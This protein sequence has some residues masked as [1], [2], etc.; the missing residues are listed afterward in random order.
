MNEALIIGIIAAVLVIALISRDDDKPAAVMRVT[1]YGDSST[2]G[3][4]YDAGMVLQR[5]APDPVTMVQAAAGGRLLCVNRAVNG[6]TL[7]ELLAGGQ[8]A[9]SA[10]GLGEPGVIE[11]FAEQLRTDP[12]DV[13][14]LGCG[15]VD[16]L[17]TGQAVA[18]FRQNLAEAISAVRAVNKTPVV[19]GLLR[20]CDNG[21]FTPEQLARREEFDT[22]AMQVA[23]GCGALFIDLDEAGSP[24]A[25][26]DR[27]H[28]TLE[29]HQRIAAVVADHL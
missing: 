14:V 23:V 25:C 13:V 21:A 2:F 9:L 7:A 26:S 11:P 8:V 12:G 29:Y 24:A 16:A 6:L 27:V 5:Y 19:R 4:W 15:N 17:F 28:P 22:A 3:G 18:T 20:F 1:F 10:P